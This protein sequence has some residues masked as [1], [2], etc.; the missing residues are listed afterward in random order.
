MSANYAEVAATESRT[1]IASELDAMETEINYT[2]KIAAELSDRLYTATCP[3]PIDAQATQSV[4]EPVRSPLG[5]ALHDQK[6]RLERINEQ[7]RRLMASIELPR[8]DELGGGMKLTGL[9]G[10]GSGTTL[11]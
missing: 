5:Q 8:S 11:R 1:Q 10:T 9:G 7:L 4:P 6:S 2:E 3:R